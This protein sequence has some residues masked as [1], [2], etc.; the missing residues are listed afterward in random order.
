MFSFRKKPYMNTKEKY[1]KRNTIANTFAVAAI[2]TLALG[3]AFPAKADNKG[4]SNGTLKGTFA[5]TAT[6]SIVAAPAPVGPYAEVGTQTFDGKGGITVA[7]MLSA[8]GNVAPLTNTGTYT[9]NP[10]CTGTF[11]VQ[12]APGI[13]SHFYFALAASGDV[14]QAL[15][16]DP[17]AVITRIGRRQYPA[18]DWR[19]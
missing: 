1:M 13:A 17:I 10:D 8:N 19:E 14:F 5:Y 12:L 9:V 4:C 16:L 18:G 2:A 11:T 6:G 3:M 7:G 15:C